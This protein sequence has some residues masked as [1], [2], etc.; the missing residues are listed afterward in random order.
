MSPLVA[1]LPA[2]PTT[3]QHSLCRLRAAVSSAISY[4]TYHKWGWQ[5]RVSFLK[6]FWV[7]WQ[8]GNAEHASLCRT[9]R[10]ERF[11]DHNRPTQITDLGENTFASIAQYH[12]V[13]NIQH[14]G[15][16]EGCEGP[17]TWCKT[18]QHLKPLVLCPCSTKQ[19]VRAV[20]NT[21]GLNQ[22]RAS[23]TWGQARAVMQQQ[24][25]PLCSSACM[26]G[27]QSCPQAGRSQAAAAH[28][29]SWAGP[30]HSLLRPSANLCFG[31]EQ[32]SSSCPLSIWEN[33]PPPP[34][35]VWQSPASSSR[36]P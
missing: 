6:H 16:L 23:T 20:E 4:L 34:A 33:N 10:P 22:P 28:G 17:R 15:Q 35:C 25:A 21:P 9:E 36:S 14:L 8:E 3:T 26:G 27:L 11:A 18:R 29:P 24:P 32:R 30:S 13:A 5:P 19:D 2:S 7:S 1:G 12:K 31:K